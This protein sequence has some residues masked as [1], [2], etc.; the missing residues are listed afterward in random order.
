M[1]TL[2]T[3]IASAVVALSATAAFADSQNWT[4]RTEQLRTAA[5]PGVLV[6]GRNSD[7]AINPSLSSDSYAGVI[8]FHLTDRAVPGAGQQLLPDSFYGSRN[9]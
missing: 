7:G 2:K 8:A 5:M 3:L 9:R 6:E 1:T 4:D